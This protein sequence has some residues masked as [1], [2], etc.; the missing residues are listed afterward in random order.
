MGRS[1]KDHSFRLEYQNL[2]ALSGGWSTFIHSND[3]DDVKADDS[4]WAAKSVG[5]LHFVAHLHSL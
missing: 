2:F 3:E 4:G 1:Q 5:G